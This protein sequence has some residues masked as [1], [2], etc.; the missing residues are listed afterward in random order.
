MIPNSSL[1]SA[2][3]DLR[4]CDTPNSE[5]SKSIKADMSDRKLLRTLGPH[6]RIFDVQTE[7]ERDASDTDIDPFRRLAYDDGVPDV[8]G[9]RDVQ[10]W[11]PR[12]NH[13]FFI[14]TIN[15]FWQASSRRKEIAF[16]FARSLAQKTRTESLHEPA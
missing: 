2:Y 5:N 11:S 13:P 3:Y 6:S 1:G 12:L 16:E 4:S 15:G 10:V 7:K 14:V 9:I 8:T